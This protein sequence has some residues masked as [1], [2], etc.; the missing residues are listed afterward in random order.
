MLDKNHNF[1]VRKKQTDIK[2]KAGGKTCVKHIIT[3]N[4][5]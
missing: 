4:R 3:R 2:I 5:E 1:K